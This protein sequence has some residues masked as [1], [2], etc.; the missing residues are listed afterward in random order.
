MRDSG[1]HTTRRRVLFETGPASAVLTHYPAGSEM[2]PHLHERRQ[3]SFLL[4]DDIQ[5]SVGGEDAD[6]LA[7]GMCSKPAGLRHANRYGPQG[8]LILAL[9]LAEN[10]ADDYRGWRETGAVREA[11]ALAALC[12]AEPARPDL[13]LNDFLALQTPLEAPRRRARPAWLE[14][15]RDRLAE[16]G[17]EELG[18]LADAA[19]VHPVSL[20][21][22]FRRHYGVSPSLYRARCKLARAVGAVGEGE[23]IACAAVE[24]GFADQAHF[25]R[26]LKREAGLT[27]R[28]LQQMIAA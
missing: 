2:A 13:L 22:A 19:G 24:G 21:R 7:P 17:E 15:I 14:E 16:A 1:D 4:A 5:E 27:P 10:P 9:N 8:A 26:A 28:T 23:P 20:S 12:L 3:L 6:L 11:G 18:D 25:S